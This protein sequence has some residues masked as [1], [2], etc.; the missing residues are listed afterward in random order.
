VE[1]STS[2]APPPTIDTSVSRPPGTAPIETA[3]RATDPGGLDVGDR[4]VIDDSLGMQVPPVSGYETVQDSEIRWAHYQLPAGVEAYSAAIEQ[5]GSQ[6]GIVIVA[7]ADDSRSLIREFADTAFAESFQLVTSTMP[8]DEGEAVVTNGAPVQWQAYGDV[9]VIVAALPAD[10]AALWAWTH[11]GLL[12]V[13]RGTMA[14]EA[15]VE[16]MTA[17]QQQTA[18]TTAYDY[19]GLEGALYE[20][21][22]DVGEYTYGDLPRAAV[23]QNLPGAFA[24]DCL[25]SF[26]IGFV[27]SRDDPD[28]PVMRDDDLIVEASELADGC[29]HGY[30]PALRDKLAGHPDVQATSVAGVPLYTIGTELFLVADDFFARL[31]STSAETMQAMKPFIEQ[32]MA[33]ASAAHPSEPVSPTTTGD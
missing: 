1:L 18:P 13:V 15:Y 27:R 21:L 25:A 19:L 8:F 28:S 12:W 16:A 4:P 17:A 24:T 11:D 7:R 20:E 23:L 2:D 3:V 10:D 30:V 6:I 9:P 14:A 22:P 29:R 31:G 5:A 26:Y 32:F 33:S